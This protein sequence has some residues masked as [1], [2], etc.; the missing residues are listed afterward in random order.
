[1]SVYTHCGLVL[2][3]YERHGKVVKMMSDE[4]NVITMT[5]PEGEEQGRIE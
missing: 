2:H 3:L 4:R 1:M 5:V